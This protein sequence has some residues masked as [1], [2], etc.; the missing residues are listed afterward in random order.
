MLVLGQVLN[1]KLFRGVFPT[2]SPLA[3][4]H[5][6]AVVLAPL[7]QVEA[8]WLAGCR[9]VGLVGVLALWRKQPL[10]GSS[11]RCSLV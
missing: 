10:V 8:E 4:F 11:H 2:L 9:L 5:S 1:P 7:L 3:S 6:F